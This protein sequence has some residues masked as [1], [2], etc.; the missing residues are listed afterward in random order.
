M[1]SSAVNCTSSFLEGIFNVD[2][3]FSMSPQKEFVWNFLTSEWSQMPFFWVQVIDWS[4]RKCCYENLGPQTKLHALK[5]GQLHVVL[6]RGNFQC[7]FWVQHVPTKGVR[8]KFPDFRMVS[9]AVFLGPSDRLKPQ[10]VLLRKPRSTDKTTCPQ[11][12]S[13]ARRP[14]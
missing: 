10:E 4:L 1:P 6:F 5:C 3:G 9:N 8:L 14:F 7:G 13:T 12:R 2:F 11:V